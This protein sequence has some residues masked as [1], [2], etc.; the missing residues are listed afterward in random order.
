MKTNTYTFIAC[1]SDVEDASQVIF[2]VPYDSTVSFRP[3]ARFAPNAIR[4]NSYG[5][6]TY[7]SYQNHDLEDCLIADIGDLEI[8]FANSEKMVE[9]VYDQT[10]EILNLG[11]R[12]AM[13]G[14]E[15]LVTLGAVKA[16]YLQYPDLH[17]IH[18][19]AHADLRDDYLEEKLSHACVLRRCHEMVGD[20]HIHQFGIRS[21]SKDESIFAKDHVLKYHFDQESIQRLMETIKEKP[22]YLT[23]DLDVLDPSIFCGTGTPEAGGITYNQLQSFINQ[24]KNFNI[25]GFDICELSPHYDQSQVSSITAAK[26]LREVLLCLESK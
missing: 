24:L 19:D 7:S 4:E 23:I 13:I 5:L 3:G 21:M 9:M 10:N 2:G 26:V 25:I 1:D 12:P 6:E 14:G 8:P 22:V 20:N 11:K 17:I 16:A 18:L 15:H